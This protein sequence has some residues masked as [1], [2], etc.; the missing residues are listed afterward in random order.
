MKFTMDYFEDNNMY[1]LEK[2]IDRTDT[3]CTLILIVVYL[4]ITKRL[5]KTALSPCKENMFLHRDI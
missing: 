4:R 5:E 3:V 1:F 2:V